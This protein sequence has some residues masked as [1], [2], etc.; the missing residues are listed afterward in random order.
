M[1]MD[2]VPIPV[3]IFIIFA[4]IIGAVTILHQWSNVG[5]DPFW[6]KYV[7]P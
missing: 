1:R 7:I 6:M 5:V 4:L 2:Q 3:L